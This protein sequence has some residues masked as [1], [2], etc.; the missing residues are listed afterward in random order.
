MPALSTCQ[1]RSRS[2]MASSSLR[3]VPNCPVSSCLRPFRVSLGTRTVTMIAAFPM[4]I[5]A[6]PLG[7]QRLVLHVL[8]WQLLR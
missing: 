6:R 7:E 1:L 2:A 3:V 4:A 8:H 5:P